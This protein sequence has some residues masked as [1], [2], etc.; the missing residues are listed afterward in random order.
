MTA[1]GIVAVLVV[2]FLVT[3]RWFL[4]AHVAD[5]AHQR[6]HELVLAEKHGVID[7]AAVDGLA[8]KVRQLEERVK[9]LGYRPR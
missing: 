5:K 7:Q 3:W 2:G 9:T 6:A 1:L 8:G 4:A